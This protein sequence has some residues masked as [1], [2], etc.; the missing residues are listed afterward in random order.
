MLVQKH[1]GVELSSTFFVR[2]LLVVSKKNEQ[3][4][5]RWERVELGCHFLSNQNNV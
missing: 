2:R 1:D 3:L 5:I 4:F